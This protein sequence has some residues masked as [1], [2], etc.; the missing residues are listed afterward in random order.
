V[1]SRTALVT[2]GSSGIGLAI[3]SSL[4]ADGYAL[5]ITGRS[6]GKLAAAVESLPGA[7]VHAVAGDLSLPGQAEA[8]VAAHRSR[9]GSLDVLVAN[10][11]GSRRATVAETE[12][13]AVRRLLAVHVEAAFALTRA[14]LPLLR[15]PPDERPGWVI[16]TS[17]IAA[18]YP[19]AGFAAYAA[20]KAALAT[21][22]R[23]VNAE[24]AAHGVRACALCPAFVSTPLTAPIPIADMLHPDDVAAGVRFLLSLSPAAVVSELVIERA[25]AGP[26][27]P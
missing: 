26:A 14:A 17:S 10:A 1:V 9:F 11:G 23:S 15:R 8:V 2:G 12:P 4:A 20:A 18:R 24:E 6:E 25:G 5:T 16:V 19:V 13:E 27:Q 7:D 22:A 3:A 21:L